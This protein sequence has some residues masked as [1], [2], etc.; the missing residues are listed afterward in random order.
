MAT[1]TSD[2]TSDSTPDP[3][4]HSSPEPDPSLSG[5][6]DSLPEDLNAVEYV[7]VYQFPGNERRRYPALLAIISGALMLAGWIIRKDSNPVL[8]SPGVGLGGALLI[9]FGCYSLVAATPLKVTEVDA[10]AA[11]SRTVGFPVGHA[12]AQMGWRGL[13]SR[14]TWRILLYSAEN[15]PTQRGLVLVDGNDGSVVDHFV[16]ENPEDWAQFADT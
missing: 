11:A 16:E 2:S 3:T 10:L 4:P 8:V 9:A 6:T 13:L 12:S 14:P 15:P 1:T 7:G 5:H